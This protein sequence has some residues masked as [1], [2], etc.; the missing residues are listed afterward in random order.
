MDADANLYQDVTET[1]AVDATVDATVILVLAETIA[2]YGLSFFLSSVAV[3]EVILLAVMDA[4]AMTAVSGS[5]FFLSSVA[6]V[7]TIHL[8]TTAVDVAIAAN[9]KTLRTVFT[10]LFVY[11]KSI[12]FAVIKRSEHSYKFTT[13]PKERLW[14]LNPLNL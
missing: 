13:I 6:V 5:F 8:A 4:A 9:R 2:V 10:V 7:V 11:N 14:N 12:I 1:V 3:V